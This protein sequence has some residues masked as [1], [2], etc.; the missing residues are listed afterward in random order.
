MEWL[1]ELL[2]TDPKA[3]QVD[4]DLR[5]LLQG[6]AGGSR[7]K[8]RLGRPMPTT[9]Q[10]GLVRDGLVP[11]GNYRTMSR[12]LKGTHHKPSDWL[13]QVVAELQS[14][15]VIDAG[16]NRQTKGQVKESRMEIGWRETIGLSRDSWQGL[17]K[18]AKAVIMRLQGN[19]ENGQMVVLKE[20]DK[21]EFFSMLKGTGGKRTNR[22]LMEA[23]LWVLAVTEGVQVNGQ[24]ETLQESVLVRRWDE[25]QELLEGWEEALSELLEVRKMVR[26]WRTTVRRK[27]QGKMMLVDWY[28][29]WPEVMR[30]VWAEEGIEVIAVDR[31]K[32]LGGEHRLNVQLELHQLAPQFWRLEVARL[33]KV[34]VRDLGPNWVGLPCTTFSRS[35]SSNVTRQG[36]RVY[37][38]YRDLQDPKRGPQHEAG[39]RK[40]DMARK[41]DRMLEAVWWMLLDCGEGWAIE[42][43]DGQLQFLWHMKMEGRARTMLRLD[44][45]RLWSEE[46]RA[47]GMQWQKMSCLWTRRKDGAMMEL[48]D[49]LK[50]RGLC[51]CR[52]EGTLKHVVHMEAMK[53][54]MAR[55]GKGR[56]EL[57]CRYPKEMVRK[58]MQW[59]LQVGGKR[60]P[61]MEEQQQ[62]EEGEQLR[63]GLVML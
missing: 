59:V 58:W 36:K 42:N 30:E 9:K 24:R 3:R 39:T 4:H 45:C 7:K 33:V 61:D 37:Y 60:A 2:N 17:K 31:R 22:L 34:S 63:H 38:N 5:A 44:Y 1:Q 48:G 8:N 52:V 28:A 25:L 55:T 18:Q 47:L 10:V 27:P 6:M 56:E 11:G 29:G 32:D 46:E 54:A 40:G 20:E 14:G 49:T 35:D 16:A 23:L 26:G 53:T 13:W 57:K 41:S 15:E 50:C 12:M 43:P 51:Q 19:L 21:V 62:R